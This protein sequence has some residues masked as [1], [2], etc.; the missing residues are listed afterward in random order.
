MFLSRRFAVCAVVAGVGMSFFSAAPAQA[1]QIHSFKKS[2]AL[3]GS[4]S[5]IEL[6]IN[7]STG[8]VYVSSYYS[9]LVNAFDASG[10]SDP[11]HPSL[12]KT[13]GTTPYPFSNPYGI[14]VDNSGG[15]SEGDIY[16]ADPGALVV[17][18]FDPSGVRTPQ[19][20]ITAANVPR[21]GTEQAGGLP[22]VVNYGAFVP[23]GLA[24]A[25]DGNIYVSDQY[26]NAIDIFE[27]DGV[28]VAQVATGRN[29][30]SIDFDSHGNLYAPDSGGSG[31]IEFDSSG[32]CVDSCAP[33]GG[34]SLGVAVDSEDHVYST[35]ANAVA[36]FNSSRERIDSFGGF[37]GRD[38]A[39]NNSNNDVYVV[40]EG[41]G[42]VY[43]FEPITVPT[44]TPG[45]VNNPGQTSGTVTGNVDPDA[46]HGGGSVTAC[47]FE[48]GTDTS[49][50][51]GTLP[52]LDA[53]NAVVGSLA[54]PIT[55]PTDVH[56]DISALTTETSYHYRLVA[57]NANGSGVGSDQIFTPHAVANL[58]TDPASNI[59][60]TC[61]AK[62]LLRRE[63]PTP[64]I[65]FNGV[66][67]RL[68]G[69]RPLRLPGSMR[70]RAPVR[71]ARALT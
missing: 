63:W 38:V 36:V 12:T 29:F 11:T 71:K 49:Y 68:T 3:P 17:S 51:L 30:Y 33:I 45:P 7:Q 57:G 56:A 19:P 47:H 64:A 32:A 21:N 26:S 54:S 70:G 23:V 61:N 37:S 18:Q 34:S 4:A 58:K 53:G 44:V 62:W 27:P 14:A 66:P 5:P 10:A 48:Y 43:I 60:R 22:P 2:F 46:A 35:E 31:V 16:V 59:D 1:T 24:V 40:N 15:A 69:I 28:F 9:R 41:D 8:E 25:S 20:P 42:L 13:D 52:C 65:T 50:A 6:A 39:V 55:T 67:I